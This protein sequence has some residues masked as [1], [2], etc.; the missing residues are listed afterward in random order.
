MDIPIPIIKE[1]K[2]VMALFIYHN[3]NNPLRS[4]SFT[5]GLEYANVRPVFKKDNKQYGK[6]QTRPTSVFPSISKV[7]ERLMYDQLHP[8][9]DENF[10]KLQCSFR[11]G[12][13]A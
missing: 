4:S 11:K 13:N 1:N 6:L 2:H 9:F 5:T 7:Y 12:Y 3:F 10:S 8:Y